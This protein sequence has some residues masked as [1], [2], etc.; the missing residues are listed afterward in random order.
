MLLVQRLIDTITNI[1][2]A[3]AKQQPKATTVLVQ[4]GTL[5]GM[6]NKISL[7]LRFDGE[8]DARSFSSA[9]AYATT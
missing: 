3:R 4:Y 7:C 5:A 8:I 1:K 9:R 2:T 6:G